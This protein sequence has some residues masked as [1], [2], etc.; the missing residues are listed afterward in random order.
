MKW[1]S[2]LF[3]FLPS[4]FEVNS[5]VLFQ[6]RSCLNQKKKK[7]YLTKK[8]KEIKLKKK[9]L[10]LKKSIKEIWNNI[11][12]Q[13]DNSIQ[14]GRPD[15]IVANKEMNICLIVNV[16][17]TEEHNVK[18]E[19]RLIKGKMPGPC[20][21]TSK[22]VLHLSWFLNKFRVCLNCTWNSDPNTGIEICSLSVSSYSCKI[23]TFSFNPF[24]SF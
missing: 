19:E 24:F 20:L 13:T 18:A 1:C 5:V 2:E 22:T 7:K 21:G 9:S 14:A 8:E 12:I 17:E 10:N 6:S 11:E 4:N 3:L 23:L 16:T 15:F